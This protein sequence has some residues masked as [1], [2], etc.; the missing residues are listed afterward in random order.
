MWLKHKGVLVN[1][2]NVK[3]VETSGR[4]VVFHFINDS[5]PLM[6]PFEDSQQAENYLKGF[7]IVSKAEKHIDSTNWN[8]N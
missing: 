5:N 8:L 4:Y 3:Y 7:F 6:I 2:N 1:L